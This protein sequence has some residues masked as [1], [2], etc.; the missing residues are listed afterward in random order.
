MDN[1]KEPVI[2][3][4]VPIKITAPTVVDN[5]NFFQKQWAKNKKPIMFLGAIA[6]GYYLY[7][8]FYKKGK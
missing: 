2:E 7:K 6:V 4:E 5:R 1:E 8:N 3:N